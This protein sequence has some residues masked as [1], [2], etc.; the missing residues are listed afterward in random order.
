MSELPIIYNISIDTLQRSGKPLANQ[1]GTINSALYY[2]AIKNKFFGVSPD[3]QNKIPHPQIA[4][5][6]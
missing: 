5:R 2:L 3:G 1:T 6:L 4:E